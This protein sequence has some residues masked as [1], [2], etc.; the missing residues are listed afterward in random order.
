M[1]KLELPWI[2]VEFYPLLVSTAWSSSSFL[3]DEHWLRTFSPLLFKHPS[4]APLAKHK[5]FTS[6]CILLRS[7][8]WTCVI[9]IELHLVMAFTSGTLICFFVSS[10]LARSFFVE[11][12]QTKIFY[13]SFTNSSHFLL[14]QSA[15]EDEFG[16][17][18]SASEFFEL[19]EALVL[20]SD[21]CQTFLFM[22]WG[23]RIVHRAALS[24]SSDSHL[25][26][27]CLLGISSS[28]Q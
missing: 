19:F 12:L 25:F 5:E 4:V 2:V 6:H 18:I 20:S 10:E 16:L 28:A 22:L 7:L 14:L 1:V 3:I 21:I 13:L 26:N 24:T 15:K 23:L 9:H 8:F 27:A 11:R 17:R